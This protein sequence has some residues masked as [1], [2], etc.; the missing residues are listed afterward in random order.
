MSNTLFLTFGKIFLVRLGWDVCVW[1]S[2]AN[3]LA[4]Q[5]FY[6]VH[7]IH[8][9]RI[10]V[11]QQSADLHADV[12]SDTFLK[13][14]L[15]G[16]HPSAGQCIRG[17][18]LNTLHRTELGTLA[19]R[20]AEVHIHKSDLS[21][22]LLLLLPDFLWGLWEVVFFQPALNDVNGCHRILIFNSSLVS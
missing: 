7:V 9:H 13:A 22:A 3:G 12:T 11:G 5:L 8:P 21:R 19:T 1:F 15:N 4:D 6:Q 17:K 2:I 20:K 18:I 14:I 16:L 10:I